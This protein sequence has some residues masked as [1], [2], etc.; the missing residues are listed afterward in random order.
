MST[1]DAAVAE[2]IRAP[3]T[4]LD[5]M[6]ESW[7]RRRVA[8]SVFWTLLVA[9][10]VGIGTWRLVRYSGLPGEALPGQL[11]AGVVAVAAV[12]LGRR[13]PVPAVVAA[14]VALLV[15]G[16]VSAPVLT[17][18]PAVL[19]AYGLA[20]R[21]SARTALAGL[22]ALEAAVVGSV[23]VAGVSTPVAILTPTT[24]ALAVAAACGLLVRWRRAGLAERDRRLRAELAEAALRRDVDRL[25][26][27]VAVATELHD[28]VGHALTAVV[29]LARG[30][31][32]ALETDPASAREA[33]TLIEETAQVGLDRTRV[34][35]RRLQEQQEPSEAAPGDADDVARLVDRV[36][37]TG[38]E[39]SLTGPGHLTDPLVVAVVREALTNALRYADPAGPVA[40]SVESA[41]GRTEV[42]VTSRLVAAGVAVREPESTRQGLASLAVRVRAAQGTFSAGAVD[43]CWVVAASV[44]GPA[45]LPAEVV[46]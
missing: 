20:R 39:V 34:V 37:G 42:R 18:V 14:V 7:E 46:R 25:A 41:G 43:G 24:L 27:R 30:A 32:A 1:M 10:Y 29:S 4:T 21:A 3:R 36:R 26:T 35:V 17:S 12:A 9:A 5:A 31:L 22:V 28:S 23:L 2:A 33:L 6:L 16:I 40:V 45:V 19:V 8:V 11:V 38:R 15:E 44:P 13:L